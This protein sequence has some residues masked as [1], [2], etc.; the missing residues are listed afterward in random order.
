VS[1]D[2]VG[3]TSGNST[4]YP[5]GSTEPDTSGDDGVVVQADSD[6]VSE[7]SW[8]GEG[9]H[10]TL[11][12]SKSQFLYEGHL[13]RQSN[14]IRQGPCLAMLCA[15]RRFG[16]AASIR[17]I[18]RYGLPLYG[19]YNGSSFFHQLSVVTA[20]PVVV[21]SGLGVAQYYDES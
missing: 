5:S 17:A 8:G 3:T 15:I 14:M 18:T 7:F 6:I 9:A 4:L 10:D 16:V 1:R 2:I 11:I 21:G 13:Q 19:S 20:C 12:S